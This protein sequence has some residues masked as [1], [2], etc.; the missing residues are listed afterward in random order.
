MEFDIRA[1]WHGERW[2]SC[3]RNWKMLKPKYQ[4]IDWG[5][6][7]RD[8]ASGQANERRLA[9]WLGSNGFT[10]VTFGSGKGWD[11]RALKGKRELSFEVKTDFAETPNIAIEYFCLRRRE[12]SGIMASEA[13]YWVQFD[14]HGDA[15][16][17]RTEILRQFIR[18]SKPRMAYGGDG[19]DAL[20]FLVEKKVLPSHRVIKFK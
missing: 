3:K 10:D 5:K 11:V 17:F 2:L 9:S 16:M 19:R 8:L 12:P 18:D 1:R 13:E 15:M 4:K 20:M 7:H 14:G 6:F